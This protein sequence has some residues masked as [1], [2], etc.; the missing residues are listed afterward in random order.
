LWWHYRRI[1]NSIRWRS[2]HGNVW[3]GRGPILPSS[4]DDAE[5][6][7]DGGSDVYATVANN[8][9]NRRRS[10]SPT[11]LLP[12][13]LSFAPTFTLD[14]GPSRLQFLDRRL[15]ECMNRRAAQ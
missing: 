10:R 5:T 1:G 6:D 3:R 2:I 8:A 4:P 13:A 7:H 14:L 9:V 12:L 11:L 15:R